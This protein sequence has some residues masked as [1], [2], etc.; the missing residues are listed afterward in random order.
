MKKRSSIHYFKKYFLRE[1]EYYK[2]NVL[3]TRDIHINKTTC[4]LMEDIS[5]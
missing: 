3:G 2:S 5:K 1:W 4:I